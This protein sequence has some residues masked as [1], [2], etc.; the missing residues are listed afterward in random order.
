MAAGVAGA[1]PQLTLKGGAF[2]PNPSRFQIL[3]K[4]LVNLGGEY[5]N[6]ISLFQDKRRFEI[7]LFSGRFGV[8]ANNLKFLV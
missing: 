5:F 1:A 4:I 8:Y 3:C 7:R 6:G 2:P